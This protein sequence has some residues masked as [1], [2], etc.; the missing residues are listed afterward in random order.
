MPLSSIL[1]VQIR[2]DSLRRYE[3]LVQ[4]LAQGAQEQKEPFHWTAHM[5]LFG[6][7]PTIHFVSVCEDF[8]AL[9]ERGQ[10]PEMVLRVLGEDEG[11]RWFDEVG[12]ATLSQ[13]ILIAT[14]RPDLSYVRD[15]RRPQDNP[16]A[17]VTDLRI[18]PGAREAFEELLR[19]L[20][21]AIPKVDDPAQ[22]QAS[23][24]IVG[25][26]TRYYVVR[27]LA[28]LADLDAQRSPDVLLND[29]FGASEGG[30]IFR[31]GAEAIQE[32]RREV[33]LY[34]PDLSNPE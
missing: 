9:Q 6:Q 18:R 2:P 16:L 28:E 25:D 29:A 15:E 32:L 1:S 5:T 27:P 26:I 10:T 13:E 30:L 19:K 34:R 11:G 22:Q 23:Q 24:V 4:Q 12:A 14:D 8:A 7:G 21:Q 20:S 31:G 17:S 33:V 3:E